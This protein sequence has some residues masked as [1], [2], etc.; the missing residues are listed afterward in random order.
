[1]VRTIKQTTV[2]EE[3]IRMSPKEAREMALLCNGVAEESNTS[4][5][6][7]VKLPSFTRFGKDEF[8]IDDIQND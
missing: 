2:R 1:M 7:E 6:E 3:K 8:G 4:S 5:G